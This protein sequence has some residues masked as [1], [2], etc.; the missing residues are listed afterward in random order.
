MVKI[1]PFAVEQ[2]MDEYETTPGVLNISETC[3]ASISVDQLVLLNR[4]KTL[5]PPPV[6]FG[7]AM[8]YGAIRGSEALRRGIAKTYSEDD[9]DGSPPPDQV[10]IQPDD[11][12]VTQ[13]AIGAN[14]LVFYSLVGP[15]DHVVCVHP[16]YQQ[17]YSVPAS[18]GAEVSLWPLRAADGFVPDVAA[19]E[20]LIRPNTK[21]IV[22]NNPNNPTGAVIP[23]DVLARIADVAR[24]HDIILFSDEVYRPLYHSLTIPTSTPP[25]SALALGYDRTVVTGSMSKAWALAG[26]RVGWLASR[27]G[28]I[29]AAA[30]AARD[31]TAISVSQV[32]DQIAA[33]ALGDDVRPQLRARNAALARDNLAMLDAFVAEHARLGLCEW[34]RPQAGTTAFVRFY[35][36]ESDDNNEGGKGERGRR[37]VD[38]VAFCRDLLETTKVMLVPGSRCFGG[39]GE[40]GVQDFRGYV[41]F[42]YASETEVLEQALERLGAYVKKHLT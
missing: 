32:D 31:Y 12:I 39:G 42:G 10:A 37:P 5:A 20:G 9:D 40:S 3:A 2:W 35:R 41:R 18:L 38:D 24:R 11:V 33:Y 34:V 36:Y 16:T 25:P 23:R 29:L 26:I 14:Y 30:A 6:D 28:G 19:L 15:G 1:P 8:T 22:I 7:R 4:L 27:D 17:L 13:G 21:M